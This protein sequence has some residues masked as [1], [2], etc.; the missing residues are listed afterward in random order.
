M[1]HDATNSLNCGWTHSWMSD[2]EYTVPSLP[3]KSSACTPLG[4][5][6]SPC[7]SGDPSAVTVRSM[8]PATRAVTN[9]SAASAR[10]VLP[11]R[12]T[13]TPSPTARGT[14]SARSTSSPST[15]TI[16]GWPVRSL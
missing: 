1:R 11:E 9:R 12:T 6:S 15:Y 16:H 7:T 5:P 13:D 10:T 8:M 2:G 4:D 14:P 3:V